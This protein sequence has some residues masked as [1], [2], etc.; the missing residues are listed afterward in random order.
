MVNT[1]SPLAPLLT[2]VRLGLAVHETVGECLKNRENSSDQRT[3]GRSDLDEIVLHRGVSG[4]GEGELHVV[5]AEPAHPLRR[6]QYT[7]RQRNTTDLNILD[8]G[9]S[10]ET[11]SV[12][13]D[14]KLTN[15]SIGPCVA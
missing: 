12:G 14:N 7:A 3:G 15:R 5:H 2:A 1:W 9:Q 8:L 4:A 6:Y 10:S 11:I 13:E